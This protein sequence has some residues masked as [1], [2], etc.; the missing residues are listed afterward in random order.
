MTEKKC[1]YQRKDGALG[2]IIYCGKIP[3]FK[4]W[5]GSVAL[6]KCSEEICPMIKVESEKELE[7]NKC[8]VCNGSGKIYTRMGERGRIHE[9]ECPTCLGSG[10]INN[11]K[12]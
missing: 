11:H 2:I 8:I 1:I 10:K 7:M 6:R 5:P 4:T 12:E 9:A 3:P